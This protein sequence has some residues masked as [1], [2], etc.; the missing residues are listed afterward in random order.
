MSAS[1]DVEGRDD[2][3]GWEGMIEN[4]R[5]S[6]LLFHLSLLI[7]D[8]L[9]SCSIECAF[10]AGLLARN[11]GGLAIAKDS[12]IRQLSWATSPRLHSWGD[13]IGDTAFD[14]EMSHDFD[15]LNVRIVDNCVIATHD[16][17]LGKQQS[18]KGNET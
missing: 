2:R 13:D 8:P 16:C 1:E 11:F 9:S 10:R 5:A 3:E 12:I 14:P 17:M 18:L 15:T 7:P 6:I 4:G